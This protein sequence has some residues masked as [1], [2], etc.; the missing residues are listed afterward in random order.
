MY[1]QQHVPITSG[2]GVLIPV[3]ALSLWSLYIHSCCKGFLCELWFPLTPERHSVGWLIHIT[4]L[5]IVC[6]CGHF[7]HLMTL[8]RINVTENSISISNCFGLWE[9][10]VE[11]FIF[12]LHTKLP[13][14]ASVLNLNTDT[15]FNIRNT[16]WMR[17]IYSFTPLRTSKSQ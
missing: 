11:G 9:C 5:P 6:D 14:P 4:R 13:G 7:P 12:N 1:K 8:C 17:I 2:A 16:K 15:H 3:S 10:S